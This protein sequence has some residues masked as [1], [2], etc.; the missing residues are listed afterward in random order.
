MTTSLTSRGRALLRLASFASILVLAFALFGA[1][2]EGATATS[3]TSISSNY[4]QV[5]VLPGETL[6]QL[7]QLV[8]ASTGFRGDL[9]DL[10]DEIISL[11]GLTSPAIL[12]GS[13][14]MIPVAK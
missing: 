9:R 8:G 11:N 7:A 6:W 13:H 3:S 2:A 12:A 4:Q 1:K 14:L 10:V 5:T